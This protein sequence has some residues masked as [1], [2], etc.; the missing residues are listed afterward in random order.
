MTV[1]DADKI[2]LLIW[3]GNNSKI[4]DKMPQSKKNIIYIQALFTTDFKI[5]AERDA[6][7]FT[8]KQTIALVMVTFC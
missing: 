4:P 6:Q 5:M 8:Y 3:L 2:F 7:K 1:E